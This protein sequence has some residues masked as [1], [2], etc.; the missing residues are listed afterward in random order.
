[1][2]NDNISELMSCACIVVPWV[3]SFAI[4]LRLIVPNCI[5][6]PAQHP[7]NDIDRLQ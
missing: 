5:K 1:M 6:Q 7:E 4:V 3:I 2:L